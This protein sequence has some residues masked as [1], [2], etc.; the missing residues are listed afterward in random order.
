MKNRK[1]VETILP[2]IKVIKN[3]YKTR[4]FKV[5]HLVTDTE[6]SVLYIFEITLM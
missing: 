2:H 5:T 4:G 3:I 1:K 6:F